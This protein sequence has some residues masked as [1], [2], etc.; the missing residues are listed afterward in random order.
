MAATENQYLDI[1]T[2]N[3]DVPMYGRMAQRQHEIT[4]NDTFE[5]Y[6]IIV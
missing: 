5:F 3:L 6:R 4:G 2:E 1:Y